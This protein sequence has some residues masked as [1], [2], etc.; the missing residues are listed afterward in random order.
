MDNEAGSKVRST[1]K[2]ENY[3]A[4]KARKKIKVKGMGLVLLYCRIVK[5]IYN[6]KFSH[7]YSEFKILWDLQ[8]LTSLWDCQGGK[9]T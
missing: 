2:W 3:N 5:K 4:I 7:N 8:D 9:I 1:S 6:S